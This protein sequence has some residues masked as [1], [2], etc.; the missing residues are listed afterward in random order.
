MLS[1][2]R[3]TSP[4]QSS[5]KFNMYPEKLIQDKN[6]HTKAKVTCFLRPKIATLN[7]TLLL[8]LRC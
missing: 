4:P 1:K 5:F 7:Q 8:H 6:E 2:H 3:N